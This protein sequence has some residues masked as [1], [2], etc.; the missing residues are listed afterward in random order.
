V[1][2]IFLY[3]LPGVGKLTVA[4]EL[5]TL[6][7]FKIFHNHQTVDLVESIFEFGS[8]PFVRLRE[9]IWLAVL[10]EATA[11]MVPGLIFTFAFDRTVRDGFIE[12]V[13]KVVEIDKGTV[14]FVE[15]TCTREEL[16]NRIAQPSRKAFGKLSD[17]AHFREL[18]DAGAFVNAGIPEDRLV[19]DTTLIS[20]AET[21]ALI[22]NQ[23]LR[24]NRTFDKD[25]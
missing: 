11:A 9:Q 13:R 14:D 23:I 6:S 21:A 20:A 2:L 15:L 25:K 5:A 12:Q 7:S 10:T 1:R 16:E 19:V 3:G 18:A 22:A 17:V 24:S 4:R 8:E